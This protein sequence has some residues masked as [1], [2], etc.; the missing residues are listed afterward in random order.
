[1]RALIKRYG[2]KELDQFELWR[3]DTRWGPIYITISREPAPG[4]VPD[5]YDLF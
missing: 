1:M 3:T 4:V 2:E 5:A